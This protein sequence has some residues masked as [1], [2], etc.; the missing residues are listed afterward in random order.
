MQNARKLKDEILDLSAG[1]RRLTAG[2]PKRTESP[3]INIEVTPVSISFEPNN[4]FITFK[5]S[6]KVD[7]T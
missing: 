2:L 5:D 1:L 6:P 3:E 4:S 7:M